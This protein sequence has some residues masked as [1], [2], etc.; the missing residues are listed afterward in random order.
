MGPTGTTRM[1]RRAMVRA[2]LVSVA[3]IASTRWDRS[4]AIRQQR[5]GKPSRWDRF[6]KLGGTEVSANDYRELA[7]PSR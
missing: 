4:E 3:P 1:D 5:V 6:A 7:R 2:N